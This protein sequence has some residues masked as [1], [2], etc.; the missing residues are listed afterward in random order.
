MLVSLCTPIMNRL[1]D[2]KET[3]SYKII[4]A[5]ENPPIEI[6][7]LDYNSTD[8]LEDYVRNLMKTA[9]LGNG[10]FF[11]YKKFTGRTTFHATHSYNLAM[12]LG[13]GEYVVLVPADVIIRSG[14]MFF[15]REE[16]KKNCIWINT[17]HKRRSTIAIKKEEFINMGGYDE[18]FEFYGPDDIDIMERLIRR[19]AKRGEIP[20]RYLKDIFTPADKKIENYR[21]KM[22]HGE[23]GKMLMPFLYEN[24]EK[25]QLMA[26]EGIEWGKW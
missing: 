16:I 14:Y 3:I 5:Q 6:V 15:L 24:R 20:D 26:N 10:S 4:A 17:S 19:N 12:L 23:M 7:I 8:G 18:R 13:Q 9:T 1:E 22:S 2:F 21:L 25:K 11:T